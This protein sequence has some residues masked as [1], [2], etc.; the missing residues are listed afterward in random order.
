MRI[1]TKQQTGEERRHRPA[2]SPIPRF[3]EFKLALA[4]GSARYGLQYADT[5]V[6]GQ[7]D[8]NPAEDA[9]EATR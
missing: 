5:A 1:N 2:Q 7:S 8:I 3:A 4:R 6:E 9:A